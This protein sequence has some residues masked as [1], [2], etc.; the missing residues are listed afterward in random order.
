MCRIRRNSVE[1][2]RRIEGKPK[3]NVKLFAAQNDKLT[4]I[5]SS[6][7]GVQDV[8]PPRSTLRSPKC[9]PLH[10]HNDESYQLDTLT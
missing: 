8:I 5:V 2:T 7:V 10:V 9:F 3:K 1:D 4:Y 6:F